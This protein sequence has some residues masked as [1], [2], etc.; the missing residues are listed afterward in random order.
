[1]IKKRLQR[2]NFY[3]FRS[4][5]FSFNSVHLLKNSLNYRSGTIERTFSFLS[6]A[7]PRTYRTLNLLCDIDE[8]A[9]LGSLYETKVTTFNILRKSTS[10]YLQH[11]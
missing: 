3:T 10:Q 1:M 2:P 8:L 6:V 7:F 4:D 11:L 5:E 9:V